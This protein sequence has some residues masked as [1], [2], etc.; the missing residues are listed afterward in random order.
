MVI[1]R[2]DCICNLIQ[3]VYYFNL[4]VKFEMTHSVHIFR[5][6]DLTVNKESVD[7]E[8]QSLQQTI[9]ELDATCQVKSMCC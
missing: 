8:C 7:K 2:F 1:C 3:V 6:Q 4:S 9:I 5:L